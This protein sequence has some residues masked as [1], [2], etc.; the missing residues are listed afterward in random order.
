MSTSAQ[1]VGCTLIAFAAT[2]LEFAVGFVFLGFNFGVSWPAFNA[3]VA[4][5]TTGETRQQYFGINFALV[6]LGIGVGGIIGGFYADVGDPATFTAIFLADAACM[7]VP[8][9]LLLGPLRHVHAR[10]ERPHDADGSEG[11]YLSILRQ[12]VVLWLTALTFLGTFVGY[13]Q[14]EAGLPA[15]AR[16][17]SEVS[18]RVIGIGFAVNTAT[19]VLL[20]FFVLRRISGHRRTRVLVVMTVLWAAAW[21][22]LG[23]T[24]LVPGTAAAA[25]GVLAFNFVFALGET[26]LQP[27]IP[28]ITNDMAPDHLRG[29]HNAVNAGAFQTHHPGSRR[30]RVHAQPRLVLGLRVPPRGRLRTHGRARARPR[31]VDL[32]GGQRHHRGRHHPAH[33]PGHRRAGRHRLTGRRR[34]L[35]VDREGHVTECAWKHVLASRRGAAAHTR[36][37]RSVVRHSC[38]SLTDGPARA[39]RRWGSCSPSTATR[40]R[41]RRPPTR[42]DDRLLGDVA[43][44][45]RP[46]AATGLVEHRR[47]AEQAVGVARDPGEL[48]AGVA[49]D[50]G[51]ALALE[52][53]HHLRHRTLGVD[54]RLGELLADPQ[55][56]RLGLGVRPHDR[57]GDH[58][59][60]LVDVGALV[61]EV[62]DQLGLTLVPQEAHRDRLG[63]GVGAVLARLVGVV[64]GVGGVGVVPVDV[65]AASLLVE[66]A[67]RRAGGVVVLR[68]GVVSPERS[69]TS[70]SK[71]STLTR[72]TMVRVSAS[73]TSRACADPPLSERT[74]STIASLTTY[75]SPC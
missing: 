68:Q 49:G 65:V 16:T 34:H 19:I 21:L 23:L 28:A 63:H 57:A 27:T 55:A 20:Q 52:G 15:F 6:N 44:G 14:I 35:R 74:T 10:A 9:A 70:A 75:S 22:V 31:A 7:L 26:L 43:V 71:P 73:R 72:G 48:G 18:T 42:R 30:G 36:R 3:M 29:R 12:P 39:A 58:P 1:V 64:V 59:A 56:L 8:I 45:R 54:H 67:E 51:V 46:D 5:V 25:F 47:R 62:H 61:V 41:P 33:R 60:P 13:G 38:G 17:V 37:T 4:A 50:V 11:S 53:G 32:A 69:V 2:P 66:L 40:R 24:G